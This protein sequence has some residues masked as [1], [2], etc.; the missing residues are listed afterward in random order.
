MIDVIKAGVLSSVQDLGRRG[1]RHLG[2]ALAGAMDPL[3]F[4]IANRLVGNPVDAAAIEI[5]MGPVALR[6]THATRIAITGT[7]FNATLDDAH[8]S[9]WWSLPVQAGQCLTLRAARRGMRAYV[10]V[11]GGIDVKPVLGSRSTDLKA[12]F[13]GL[14]GRAL[15]DGDRLPHGPS[16]ALARDSVFSPDAP[17]FGVKAP[18]WS[19]FAEIDYT[20]GP[21][22]Y[23]GKVPVGPTIVVRVLR[24]HEYGDFTEASHEAFWTRDWTITPNSNRVGYRLDG[25]VLE[26]GIGDELR[27][28]AVLPGTIQV[29]PNGKPIVLLA[30]AQTTGGYPKIGAVISADLWRLGQARL[31]SAVRFVECTRDEALE[32]LRATQRYLTQVAAALDMKQHDQAARAR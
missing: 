9:S 18:A 32:A 17:T 22:H 7:D 12:G 15:R 5:T 8:V 10:A 1:H 24:G 4:E 28:H 31:G 3:S 20:P 19:K 13:G 25:P 29:P 23:D 2:V 6:F 14:G 30:D 21:P 11:A 26:R 16:A 27:S